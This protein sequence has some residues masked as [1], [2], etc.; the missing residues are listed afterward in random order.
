MKKTM[1]AVAA[2][3]IALSGVAQADTI[4]QI[5]NQGLGED[6]PGRVISASECLQDDSSRF[7]CWHEHDVDP[8]APAAGAA[9]EP[10][11]PNGNGNGPTDP[12]PTGEF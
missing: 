3:M 9:E 1:T 4:K 2:A 12:S 11:E 8:P 10:E 5:W 7:G 6:N